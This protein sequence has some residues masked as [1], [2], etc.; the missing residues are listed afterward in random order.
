MHRDGTQE[1]HT[2]FEPSTSEEEEEEENIN[3]T[4]ETESQRHSAVCV[5]V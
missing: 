3:Q 5:Q 2:S 1:R 4:E